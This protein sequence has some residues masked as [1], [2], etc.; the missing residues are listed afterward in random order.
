LTCTLYAACQ[1]LGQQGVD[2]ARPGLAAIGPPGLASADDVVPEQELVKR[3]Q[4]QMPDSLLEGDAVFGH[5]GGEAQ[6]PRR[7]G[8]QAFGPSPS[9][10]ST[11]ALWVMVAATR[12]IWPVIHGVKANMSAGA[13]LSIH[14]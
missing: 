11:V 7:A 12:S 14:S 8:R 4:G 2:V 3:R 1:R 6:L 10:G 5:A 13:C 9:A